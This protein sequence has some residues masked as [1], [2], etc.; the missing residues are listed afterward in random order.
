MIPRRNRRGSVLLMAIGLLTI[1][2]ILA[3]TF[4]IVSNLDAQE[5]DTL[6]TKRQADPIAE[7]IFSTAI[8]YALKD[9]W[10]DA[11][12]G[13]FGDI[14]EDSPDANTAWSRFIDRPGKDK[15]FDLD[16]WLS[17]PPLTAQPRRRASAT[18]SAKCP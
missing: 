7:A 5:A 12:D 15:K 6:A 9:L 4:L 3:S 16:E 1:V 13:P 10:V 18:S 8:A 17:E 11:N 2:A 14:E